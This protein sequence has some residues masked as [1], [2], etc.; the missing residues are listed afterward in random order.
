M[1]KHGKDFTVLHGDGCQSACGRDVLASLPRTP[2][3]ALPFL[4]ILAYGGDG[5]VGVVG[6]VFHVVP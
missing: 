5:A 4:L 1:V 6:D 2:P 3:Y